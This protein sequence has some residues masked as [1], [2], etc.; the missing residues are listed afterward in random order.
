MA[1]IRVAEESNTLDE[2]LVTIS[3]RMDQ[4]IETRLEVMVRLLEPLMLLA[5]GAMVMFIIAGVLL[6]IMDLNSAID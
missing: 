6:P 1:M 2:V 3:D 5:I 4:K